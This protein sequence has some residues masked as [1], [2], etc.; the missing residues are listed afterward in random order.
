MQWSKKF[1]VRFVWSKSRVY[2]SIYIYIKLQIHKIKTKFAPT[3]G[4]GEGQIETSLQILR[5]D[6][7]LSNDASVS[8]YRGDNIYHSYRAFGML[9]MLIN[10]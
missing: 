8:Y 1:E 5:I 2:L 9:I 3:A 4:K 6:H 7:F 10:T